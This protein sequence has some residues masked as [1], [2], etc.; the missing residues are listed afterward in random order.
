MKA[1]T[2]KA[3]TCILKLEERDKRLNEKIEA[4]RYQESLQSKQ[5]QIIEKYAGVA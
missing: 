1:L 4:P 2:L 5:E 3:I